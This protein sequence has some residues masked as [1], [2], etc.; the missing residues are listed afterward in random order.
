[1]IVRSSRL[2]KTLSRQAPR[3][4]ML[5]AVSAFFSASVNAVDVNWL[6]GSVLKIDGLTQRARGSSTAL[7]QKVLSSEIQTRQ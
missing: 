5:M 2:T 1:L 4:T 7:M 3:K 6:P